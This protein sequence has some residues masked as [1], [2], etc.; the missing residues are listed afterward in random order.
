MA[1]NTAITGIKSSQIELDVTGNNIANAS[2]VGY[3]SARTEFAD[4]Y[5]S[6][7]LGAGSSN[8]P[9]AG[10]IVSDIAQDFSAGTIQFTNNNLDLA[11]DG[12]GF[13]QLDDGQG[14]VTYT[15]VGRFELDKDGNVVSKNGKFLQGYGLDD[16]GNLLPVGNLTVSATESPPKATEN[17]SLA[18]NIDSA[19]DPSNLL[20]PYDPSNTATYTHSTTQT[21]FDSLGNQHTLKF[22]YVE[23]PPIRERQEIT[24]ADA[25]NTAGSIE[26]G[27]ETFDLSNTNDYIAGP[28]AATAEEIAALIASREDDLRTR[29]PRISS[30]EVDPDNPDTVLVTFAASASDVDN[31]VISDA[32]A[33]TSGGVSSQIATVTA[34]PEFSA[35]EQ[36]AVRLTAPSATTQGTIEI[37]GVSIAVDGTS[38]PPDTLTDVIN[39]IVANQNDI[40]AA[41]PNIES[42]VADTD[43]GQVLINYK[44]E[45]GNVDPLPVSES[46]VAGTVLAVGEIQSF[47]ITS[48]VTTTGN[49]LVGGQ[50]VGVTAGDTALDVATAVASALNATAGVS[51]AYNL[52]TQIVVEYE[53]GQ[54]DVAETYLDYDDN[55][56]GAASSAVSEDKSYVHAET[57]VNGDDS[58]EGVY[59]MFAYLNGTEMLD[60]GKAVAPGAPGSAGTP[61]AT[62]PGPVLITFD[63]TNGLLS[64]VNGVS[65]SGG[66]SAPIITIEGSDPADPNNFIELDISG[67]TQFGS[68]SVTKPGF[69]QDGY[70]KGDL[71]NVSFAEDG[72]MVASFSNGQ[73]TNLGVV[74][75]A[76]FDNTAGLQSVGDTEWGATLDS[77]QAIINP[78]GAGL[79]GLISSAALEQSN[80]DL[81]EELVALIE[82]QRNF[83]ANSKTLQ[84]E[85]AITQTILQ[86][87]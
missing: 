23:Q 60:I 37:G 66:G 64:T 20:Q 9:G 63:N 12:S 10:V 55:G 14:G 4:I 25:T 2:T 70:A 69:S 62:E 30:V 13:F 71:I 76:T 21:V 24:F 67:T 83:Q 34:D 28:G 44:A 77:G 74:A 38:T 31:V 33:F 80:V 22:D 15:R 18:V 19:A 82:A 56:T 75:L 8:I 1:F 58:H 85:N 47:D 52:G 72:T 53:P 32:G 26:F 45:A 49:I 46:M 42:L 36:Q 84:T 43:N 61:I 27:G 73:N 41:N 59:R 68:D 87:S 48:A 7:A 11:I 86:I 39:R 81:S 17:M 57:L 35:V 3:K 51:R 78:P 29:D 79:N 16:A 54:G 6:V 40:I 65:V 50:S 5:T